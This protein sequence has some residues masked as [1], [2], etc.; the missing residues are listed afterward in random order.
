MPPTGSHPVAAAATTS[1]SDVTSGG[2]D[3]QTSEMP[4]TSDDSAP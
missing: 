4:R 1:S 2:I 3:T